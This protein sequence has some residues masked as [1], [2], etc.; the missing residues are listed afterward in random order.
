MQKLLIITLLAAS[1]AFASQAQLMNTTKIDLGDIDTGKLLNGNKPAAEAPVAA[2]EAPAAIAAATADNGLGTLIAPAVADGLFLVRS[3]FQVQERATGNVFGYGGNQDFGISY[4][5]GVKVARGGFILSDLAMRPWNYDPNYPS[6]VNDYF[7]I[8]NEMKIACLSDS[9]Q[10]TDWETPDIAVP[11]DSTTV[12][13][14]YVSRGDF[15][16]TGLD[17]DDTPGLKHGYMVWMVADDPETLSDSPR[18]RLVASQLD[19]EAEGCKFVT[20]SAPSFGESQVLGGVYLTASYPDGQIGAIDLLLFGIADRTFD[21]W[22]IYTPFIPTPEVTEEPA[23]EEED[24][25]RH[26]LTPVGKTDK[27]H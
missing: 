19:I 8:P 24:A 18:V 10:W 5:I 6:V 17:F 15:N 7:G 9:A 23:E 13:D 26:N 11:T 3:S 4:S 2:E 21:Q 22:V 16:N 27:K 14:Y 1:T 12:P 20:V 25:I